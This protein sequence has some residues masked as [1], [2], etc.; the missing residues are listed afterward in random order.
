MFF[1]D[2]GR[3]FQVKT[4]EIA[5]ES[6]TARGESIHGFFTMDQKERITAVVRMPQDVDHDYMIMATKLGEVK[7]TPLKAFA[8]VRRD[9]LNAMDLEPADEFV[10]ARLAGDADEA[11]MVTGR[12][13]S[14]KF[15]VGLLRAASRQSGGVRGI[16]LASGDSVVGMDIARKGQALL[17]VTEFGFGKRTPVEDYP[18]QG[19]G[20]QGVITFKTTPKTGQLM[21]ARMVEVE[22]EL[23]L[24][25]HGGVVLRTPMAHISLQGRP[26]QGVTLMDVGDDDRVAAI[27][28]ID[29]RRD[30][31][32]VDALPTGAEIKTNGA[33][34]PKAK[35]GNGAGPRKPKGK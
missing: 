18:L 9:G 22:H 14:L 8:S 13:Q 11:L 28:V 10:S 21:A 15:K 35:G 17:V 3:C 33:K 25:S 27:A 2:R 12:G 16:R 4:Y 26:T 7:K 24:I 32:A 31:S 23:M 5:D 29:M 20:G 30:F 6:R 1:T 34:K 19:R